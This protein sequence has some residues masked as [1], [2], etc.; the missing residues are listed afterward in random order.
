MTKK[1]DLRILKTKRN[2]YDGLLLMMK[3]KPF[4]EIKVTDICNKALTNRS[5]FYDHFSD[6]YELLSSLMQ[7][8]EKTLSEKFKIKDEIY[9]TKEFYMDI[10]ELLLEHITENS[11]IYSSIAKNNN[12]SI[13]ADIM[14]DTLVKSIEKH[15]KTIK[16]YNSKVPINFVAVFYASAV[17]KICI[18]YIV[19]PTKYTKQELIS[20]LEELL[21]NKIG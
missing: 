8:L 6:K 10:I 21:P 7:D 12:N 14:F 17:V 4:E 15:L 11:E 9:G 19:D 16:N 5:T 1:E 20:Y 13:A 3:D 18:D 2:L